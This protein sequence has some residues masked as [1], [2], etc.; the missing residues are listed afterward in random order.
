MMRSVYLDNQESHF[1]DFFHTPEV[2]SFGPALFGQ[3]QQQHL[4]QQLATELST[5]PPNFPTN[6]AWSSAST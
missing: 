6:T 4:C 3:Q 5:L 2:A 1:P